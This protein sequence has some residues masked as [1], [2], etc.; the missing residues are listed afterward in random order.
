MNLLHK[1]EN[2]I[3]EI[4]NSDNCKALIALK[5]SHHRTEG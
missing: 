5:E 1:H 2:K 4:N 3:A